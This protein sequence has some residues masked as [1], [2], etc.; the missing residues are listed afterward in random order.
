MSGITPMGGGLQS[1]LDAHSDPA[2]GNV[3]GLKGLESMKNVRSVKLADA[4]AM[5]NPS[6]WTWRMLQL[7]IIL[8]LATLNAAVNGYD[9]SVMSSINSY[10]Q[11][12]SYFG[13]SLTEGTPATGIVYAVFTIGNLVGA[14][15]AGPAADWKGRR[16]GMFL[17]AG[18]V[19]VGAIVQ[20]SS[21]NLA[22]FMIGRFMLGTCLVASV[23]NVKVWDADRVGVGA[24]M[25]PSSAL[26]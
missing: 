20:A 11:Y 16:W 6:L 14:G 26:P 22:A 3:G 2:S 15:F 12:R 17:G 9:G 10:A 18:V 25:G 21:R 4:T 19:I 8:L 7:Y 1:H 24:A 5:Q 23:L 13:F